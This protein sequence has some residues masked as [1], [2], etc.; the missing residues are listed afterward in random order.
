MNEERLTPLLHQMTDGYS[1]WQ[2]D[3]HRRRKRRYVAV[4]V[5]SLFAA[6]TVNAVAL[7]L[8]NRYSFYA[9][10]YGPDA[11][12]VVDQMLQGQ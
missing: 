2:T 12:P 11:V 5:V 4:V 7:T 3:D 6:V 1:R 9:G 10:S 8:P